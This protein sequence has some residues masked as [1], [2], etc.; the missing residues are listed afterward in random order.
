MEQMRRIVVVDDSKKCLCFT[1]RH[2]TT[3]PGLVPSES[4]GIDV[5]MIYGVVGIV[6]VFLA[7]HIEHKAKGKWRMNTKATA[8]TKSAQRTE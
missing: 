5:Q 3:S 6:A 1:E 7:H 2:H 4:C 8:A